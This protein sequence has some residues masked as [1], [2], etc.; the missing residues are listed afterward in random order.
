MDDLHKAL[1]AERDEN[2]C[3]KAMTPEESVN[4]SN[5]I[6]GVVREAAK[7]AQKEGQKKGAKTGGKGVNSYRQKNLK[8][9]KT[10]RPAHP[11]SLQRPAA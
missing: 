10:S 5:A 7:A 8:L 4:M 1:K 2:V 6:E 3:C 11:R 9:S